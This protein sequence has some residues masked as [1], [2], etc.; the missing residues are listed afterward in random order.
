MRNN[1]ASI[2]DQTV[3]DLIIE[4]AEVIIEQQES[5]ERLKSSIE[6]LDHEMYQ[7]TKY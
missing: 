1:N 2:A 3:C 4:M 7:L 6:N 5:I